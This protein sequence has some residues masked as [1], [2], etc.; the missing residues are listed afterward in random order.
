MR[1]PFTTYAAAI[2]VIVFGAG[3]FQVAGAQDPREMLVSL[4]QLIAN[5]TMFDQKRVIVIGFV[6]LEFESQR[7]YLNEA[8]AKHV[9]TRNGVWLDVS[10][11][12]YARRAEFDRKYALVEGTFNARRRG[13]LGLSSGQ[14]ENISR[15]QLLQY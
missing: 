4:I 14:L 3:V 1:S 13:H 9:I 15:I 11:S 7:I 8:D 2:L 5:P 10:D 6:V 12:I